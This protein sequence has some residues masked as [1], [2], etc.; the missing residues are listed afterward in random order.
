MER[1]LVELTVHQL[2]RLSIIVRDA[3]EAAGDENKPELEH[4]LLALQ[5]SAGKPEI[6]EVTDR[7]KC[8]AVRRDGIGVLDSGLDQGAT[9]TERYR[10]YNQVHSIIWD[11]CKR[12][13][14][15][16]L[17]QTSTSYESTHRA[18][19]RIASRSSAQRTMVH[20]S[21]NCRSSSVMV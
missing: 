3:I 14:K 5:I 17:S 9:P 13:M 6:A 7:R 18:A 8:P 1:Y 21:E 4:L 10:R 2:E 15:R 19:S 16:L 12:V 20:D 11:G